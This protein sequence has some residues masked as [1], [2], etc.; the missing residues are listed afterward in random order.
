MFG[1]C[2]FY[3]KTWINILK[4]LPFLHVCLCIQRSECALYCVQRTHTHT[5]SPEYQSHSVWK[6]KRRKEKGKNERS[7]IACTR[8]E[9]SANY[10]ELSPMV[11][12][13]CVCTTTTSN[14]IT[15]VVVAAAVATTP[16]PRGECSFLY[17]LLLL[18]HTIT[19]IADPTCNQ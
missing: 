1:A 14:P 2:K 16:L 19:S 11:G 17:N 15:I 10:R 9:R 5:H 12:C 7:I 18:M 8:K 6:W 3:T 13:G 4:Y